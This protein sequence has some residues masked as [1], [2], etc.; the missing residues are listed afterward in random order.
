VRE[1]QVL[2][3]DE[4]ELRLRA[5]E[6]RWYLVPLLRTPPGQRDTNLTQVPPELRQ[7][8]KG[9]L[10]QWDLLPPSLQTEF[11][12]NDQTLHYF[13]GLPNPSATS[14]EQQK[15]EEQFDQFLKLTPGEE[16]KLLGT[17]SESERTKM[18]QTLATFQHLPLE[19]RALCLRNY[20]KFAGMSSD[21]RAEFLKNAAS[22][23]KMSPGERQTWRDLVVHVPMWPPLPQ[24]IMPPLPPTPTKAAK[25][26]MATN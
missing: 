19:Q 26:G 15:I 20:A 1:Y 9:R 18:E 2:P 6:L 3:P 22:W 21:D 17:L 4:R 14:A 23:S 10:L 11:L 12:T 24:S 16:K 8:V 7:L 25:G 13:T 5:T